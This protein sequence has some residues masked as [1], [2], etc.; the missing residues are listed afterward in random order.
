M[1]E[2]RGIEELVSREKKI[3]RFLVFYLLLAV[4]L[5]FLFVISGVWTFIETAIAVLLMEIV[6]T[7]LVSRGKPLHTNERVEREL[8]KIRE[9]DEY[10]CLRNEYIA[11][12]DS[13]ITIAMT[14]YSLGSIAFLFL[15]KFS[16]VYM[17]LFLT[18]ILALYFSVY[19]F[20]RYKLSK[21]TMILLQRRS[22]IREMKREKKAREKKKRLRSLR[23]LAGLGKKTKSG[24]RARKARKKKKR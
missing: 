17:V 13:T 2:K 4:F 23:R 22:V 20:F 3:F 9:I 18:G 21:V 12:K 5:A 16:V 19:L 8:S 11:N 7:G 14:V 6:I 10:T 1:V 15:M 24:K